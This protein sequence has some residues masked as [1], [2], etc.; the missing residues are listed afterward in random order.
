MELRDLIPNGPFGRAFRLFAEEFFENNDPGA[1][2]SLELLE[3]AGYRSLKYL[4]IDDEQ[5]LEVGIVTRLCAIALIPEYEQPEAGFT[6][7]EEAIMCGIV[8]GYAARKIEEG[9]I[10]AS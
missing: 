10:E 7:Q 6:E 5:S 1:D 3:E 9:S 4:G 2:A 8:L